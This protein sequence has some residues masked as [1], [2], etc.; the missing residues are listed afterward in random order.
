MKEAVGSL[1]ESCLLLLL[2]KGFYC[3]FS[4]RASLLSSSLLQLYISPVCVVVLLL[5][6]AL[7]LLSSCFH[8]PL[9]SDFINYLSYL[10]PLSFLHCC[11]RFAEL[12]PFPEI[13]GIGSYSFF[14]VLLSP[15]AK[16][17]LSAITLKVTYA[18]YY[19]CYFR[20]G[21]VMIGRFLRIKAGNYLKKM[22]VVSEKS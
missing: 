7:L 22:A 18:Q 10:S 20:N 17:F 13:E 15:A 21:V 19:S 5:C 16:T 2:L 8:L 14:I 1:F 3:R 9:F 11:I 6:T 4:N 12:N